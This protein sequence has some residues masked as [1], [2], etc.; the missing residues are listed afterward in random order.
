VAPLA[1]LN[2]ASGMATPLAQAEH[3]RMF[4]VLGGKPSGLT[5]GFHWAR[6]IEALYAAER[7]QELAAD[8]TLTGTDLRRT[9]YRVTGEGWGVVEA[10]RGTL[11]H[12]YRTDDRGIVTKANLIVATQNKLGRISLSIDKAARALIRNGE[13]DPTLLNLVEMAFRAYDPCMA[14]AT[15]AVTERLPLEISLRGPQGEVL[16]T[17]RQG[18][19]APR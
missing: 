8:G 17:L 6:L 11:L 14:C 1:R 3:D 13:A 19:A 10:P 12:H 9:D 5:L 18:F 7:L 16:R 2:A 15:H 4:E